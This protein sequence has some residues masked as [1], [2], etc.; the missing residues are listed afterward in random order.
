MKELSQYVTMKDSEEELDLRGTVCDSM[1]SMAQAVGAVAFQP[2]V[3][4]LMQA[5]EEG[6]HLGHARLKE[7]RYVFLLSRAFRLH[8]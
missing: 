7:T 6:L 3:Q 1:G 8:S 2:Y 5:S 4:P